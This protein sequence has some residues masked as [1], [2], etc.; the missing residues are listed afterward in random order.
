MEA[1]SRKNL[2][3]SNLEIPSSAIYK[4]PGMPFSLQGRH[5]LGMRDG[6]STGSQVGDTQIP[7][8]RMTDELGH[9]L[10]EETLELFSPENKWLRGVSPMCKNT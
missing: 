5:E 4:A 1:V 9:L 8:M 2:I 10:C 3:Y 7:N 6:I